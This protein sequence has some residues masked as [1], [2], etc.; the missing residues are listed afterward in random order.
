MTQNTLEHLSNHLF[1]QLERLNDESITGEELEEEMK[2]AK[3]ITNVATRIIQN[4]ELIL[5]ASIAA[6]NYFDENRKPSQLLE[7]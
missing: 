5:K 2:R 7:G 1:E 3:A 6:D 4:G